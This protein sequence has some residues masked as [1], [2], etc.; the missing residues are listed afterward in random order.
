VLLHAVVIIS[1]T[2]Y[3]V[4]EK[5]ILLIYVYFSVGKKKGNFILNNFKYNA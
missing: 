2:E 3:A 5:I 4:V 1:S